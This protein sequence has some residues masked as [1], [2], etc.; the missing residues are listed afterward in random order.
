[1]VLTQRAVDSTNLHDIQSAISTTD[2]IDE[3]H[4]GAPRPGSGHHS[5]RGV[6]CSATF[7]W[8]AM[9]ERRTAR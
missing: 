7:M 3:I 2:H 1:M 8:L 5:T 9:S 4:R 6:D